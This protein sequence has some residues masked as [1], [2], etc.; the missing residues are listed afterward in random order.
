MH[1]VNQVTQYV[2]SRTLLLTASSPKTVVLPWGWDQLL[3]FRAQRT[4]LEHSVCP[5]R[6][7][8]PL[9]LICKLF[10]LVSSPPSVFE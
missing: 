3:G 10:L 6:Q 9:G 7:P 5:A 2:E 1:L 8:V 4:V